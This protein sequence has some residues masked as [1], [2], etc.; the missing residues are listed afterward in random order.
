[1]GHPAHA[2]PEPDRS[3]FRHR[4]ESTVL[5]QAVAEYWPAFLERAEEHGGLPRFVVQELAGVRDDRAARPAVGVDAALPDEG[6]R[7]RGER[8]DRV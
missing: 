1:M 6:A 3:R 4:P 2:F 8:R 5:Y 7:R